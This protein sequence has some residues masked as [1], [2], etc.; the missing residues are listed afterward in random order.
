MK[1]LLTKF[2]VAALAVLFSG[3]LTSCGVEEGVGDFSVSVKEVGAD[4]VVLFITAPNALE[5]AYS[6]TDQPTLATPAVLFKTGTVITVNPADLVEINEGISQDTHYYLYAAA[7]ISDTEYSE[8]ITHE[9]TTKKYEFTELVSVVKTYYDGFKVHI[10]VPES[11]KEKGNVIRYGTTSLAWYNLM[12]ATNGVEVTDVNAVVANGNPY[13]NYV[14]NDSTLIYNDANIV[15][16]DKDGQPVYDEYEDTY[17]IHDPI[18]PGEPTIFLA[19]ECRYGTPE[20]WNDVMGFYAPTENGYYVPLYQWGTG[21]TGAFQKIVFKTKEPAE[22]EAKVNIEIPENEIT[23][24]DA[25]IYLEMDKGVSRYFY[26]VLDDATYNQ[27]ASTYLDGDEA[28]FQWFLTSYIAFYEWGVY[29]Y[30]E[31][32]QFNAASSF[33]QPLTGGDKYHVLVTSMGA[34][35]GSLQN[36]QHKTFTAKEKTKSSPIVTVTAVPSNDPYEVTFNVKAPNK[37]LAGAY[38]ACNYAREFEKMFNMKYTY[39]D[40]LYGN[41]TFSS[42]EIADINSDKGLTL[43]FSSLDGETTRL[44]VYG[45]NDE[46]TF[47]KLDPSVEGT[48]WADYTTPLCEPD[49]PISSTLFS[50]LEGDWTATATIEAKELV[51]EDSDETISYNVTHKSKVTISSSAPELPESLSSDVYDLYG[52]MDPS[53]VDGMYEELRDLTERYTEYRLVGQNRMLCNG[54][55]DFDYYEENG[56]LKYYSPYDLFVATNYSSVDVPQIIYDFGP[57]WFLEVLEDGKVIV[58]IDYEFLP[59]MHS[60][61]GNSYY[62]G[63]VAGGNAILSGNA[64]I[65]GFPV[66]ISDDRDTVTIKPIMFL[67]DKNQQIPAYMNAVGLTPEG[68]LEIVATVVSEIVLTR[69]WEETP[70]QKNVVVE[71]RK[72]TAKSFD[73]SEVELPETRTYKS[74]T[75]LSAPERKNFK[76]HEKP[77]VVTKE[78]VD[79]TSDKILKQYNFR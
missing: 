29:G 79:K 78:M 27:I 39:A 17:D 25:M 49:A 6:I 13:A 16:L 12:K 51:S 59:P 23:V 43:T 21:W 61:P 3:I 65:P 4:Q 63:A 72:V 50:E 69:G 57:K 58:P 1:N 35:D 11:V 10:T 28:G 2:C 68:G 46:Y 60:W 33:V 15:L 38:W 62:V 71:P 32:M 73:G 26:M 45:C 9:F 42:D 55:I 14:K 20:E 30:S 64:D 53:E 76:V 44:A 24:T 5:M 7:R 47:N 37:D 74:M 22:C 34:D 56:R 70:A 66:E 52:N 67:N 41:Y 54:F 31:S 40:L 36:F 19:G 18:A 75:E 8:V 77:N 48:G